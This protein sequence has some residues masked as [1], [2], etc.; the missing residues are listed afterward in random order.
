[1]AAD[2]KQ[3]E[4]CDR[5]KS[6]QIQ[7]RRPHPVDFERDSS[8]VR[9]LHQFHAMPRIETVQYG[10]YRRSQS[11]FPCLQARHGRGSGTSP[12]QQEVIYSSFPSHFVNLTFQ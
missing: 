11:D 10:R 6:F 9:K 2:V 1:M 5:R 8:R 3:L 4:L 7:L 12:A